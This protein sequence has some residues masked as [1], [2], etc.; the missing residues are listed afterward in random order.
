[1]TERKENPNETQ[2][3][4]EE[5]QPS[6]AGV[7]PASYTTRVVN[8]EVTLQLHYYS[9]FRSLRFFYFFPSSQC[10]RSARLCS[11]MRRNGG[12]A[13]GRHMHANGKRRRCSAT[14]FWQNKTIMIKKKQKKKLAIRAVSARCFVSQADGEDEERTIIDL[15][16]L[17]PRK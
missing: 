7:T 9:T 10:R 13:R 8:S 3:A 14:Y 6:C 16:Q 1:M 15:Q 17:R 5:E 12:D 11:S 4:T 2:W